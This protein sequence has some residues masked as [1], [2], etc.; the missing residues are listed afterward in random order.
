MITTNVVSLAPACFA[1]P[2]LI[3]NFGKPQV[4]Y[5]AVGRPD[6]TTLAPKSKPLDW[7]AFVR[8]GAKAALQIDHDRYV[9]VRALRGAFFKDFDRITGKSSAYAAGAFLFPADKPMLMGAFKCY[10]EADW[11]ADTMIMRREE[12]STASVGAKGVLV[13]YNKK[14]GKCGVSMRAAKIPF[15]SCLALAHLFDNAS[16]E[17]STMLASI[18]GVAKQSS[19]GARYLFRTIF[20][21]AST[22]GKFEGQIRFFV[23]ESV[24]VE[25]DD[26]V[27]LK[28]P[29]A[30]S[31]DSIM[32]G[33]NLQRSRY[34]EL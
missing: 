25:Y 24:T 11:L 12:F 10:R 4:Q 13:A 8:F 29:D 33:Y 31:P 3:G 2:A 17:L 15:I 1:H 32:I 26:M 20:G 6:L 7:S 18:T 21:S 27:P 23:P 16:D 19:Y 34:V 5:L 22:P 28:T 9:E 30:L 14:E